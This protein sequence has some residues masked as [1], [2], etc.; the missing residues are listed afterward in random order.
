MSKV[1]DPTIARVVYVGVPSEEEARKIGRTLV[2]ERLAGAANIIPGVTSFFWWDGE[3]REKVEATLILFTLETNID[4][5][6][7]RIRSLHSYITPGIKVW[8]VT[9]G[10]REW[11]KWL[12]GEATPAGGTN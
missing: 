11:L 6:I 3:V 2:D 7:A 4:A 12:K 1:Y 9:E 10:D 5:V 8:T